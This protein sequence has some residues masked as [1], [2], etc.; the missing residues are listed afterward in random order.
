MVVVKEDLLSVEI[1][2]I[3]YEEFSY[4]VFRVSKGFVVILN[5]KRRSLSKNLPQALINIM[6]VSINLNISFFNFSS[7]EV[8]YLFRFLC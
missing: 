8:L 7:V 6:E 5:S 1:L 2:L 4:G 3:N